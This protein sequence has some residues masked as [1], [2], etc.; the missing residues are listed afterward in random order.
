[1]YSVI[2]Q[3]ID[4]ILK[5]LAEKEKDLKTYSWLLEHI[6]EGIVSEDMEYQK[7]YRNFWRMRFLS[8]HYCRQYFRYL[9]HNKKRD[10][11]EPVAVCRALQ[12]ASQQKRDDGLIDIIQFSFATKLTHMVDQKLPIYDNTVKS[13]FFLQEPKSSL[14]FED[15]LRGY[16]SIYRFLLQEYQRVLERN[17]LQPSMRA[18]RQ[19]FPPDVF[20]NSDVKVIDWLIWTFVSLA[21]RDD[22]FLSGKF[23]H[24]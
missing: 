21:R 12:H 15:R 24:Q 22:G 13:F 19:R 9:E 17:L 5:E 7:K 8:E 3:N 2:N 1:M 11:I 10:L 18:F 23:Q 16:D 20:R 4:H 14:P 6:T